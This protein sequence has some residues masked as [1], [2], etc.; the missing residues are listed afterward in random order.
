MTAGFGLDLVHLAR[1]GKIV[2]ESD[3]RG[4]ML[5]LVLEG[6]ELEVGVFVAD[7]DL[8]KSIMAFN[9]GVNEFQS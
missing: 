3:F 6:P 8:Y 2:K 1:V 7:V 9:K 4:A 5:Q